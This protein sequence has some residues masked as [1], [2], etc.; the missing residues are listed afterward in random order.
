VPY[1]GRSD[2]GQ[3]LAI[4]DLHDSLRPPGAD[5]I[6]HGAPHAQLVHAEQHAADRQHEHS[7]DSAKH[8]T[9]TASFPDLAPCPTAIGA[10]LW[11]ARLRS[12]GDVGE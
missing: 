12:F 1:Q 9:S 3:T 8:S 2:R 10:P 7:H 4:F 6:R 5:E 11:G